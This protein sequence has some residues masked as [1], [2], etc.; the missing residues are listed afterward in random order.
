MTSR[1]MQGHSL[2]R[3]DAT[4]ASSGTRLVTRAAQGW[5]L[6]ELLRQHGRILG[7]LEALEAGEAGQRDQAQ[8]RRSADGD[9]PHTSNGNGYKAGLAVGTPAPEFEL[10]SF[11]GRGVSL[12]ALRARGAPVLLIYSDP[13]CGPCNAL[14]PDIADCQRRYAEQLTIALVSRAG[15]DGN[16]AKAEEHRQQ[17]VLL[18]D[19]REASTLY[20]A[21]GTPSAMMVSADGRIASSLSVGAVAIRALVEAWVT[22]GLNVLQPSDNGAANR[23]EAAPAVSAGLAIGSKAPS[24]TLEDLDGRRISLHEPAEGGVVLL[25]WNPRCGFCQWMQAAPFWGWLELISALETARSSDSRARPD[26]AWFEG[27][28]PA[29]P[30]PA[31]EDE[32]TT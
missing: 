32:Q 2:V 18:Q 23:E 30:A 26:G 13:G 3:F 27:E 28:R 25:F 4:A 10:P 22:G 15:A 17:T 21:H 31:T 20:Q 8:R 1:S 29:C 6:L 24:I 14:L 19:V 12:A 7:R 9:G 11:D 16:R 5:F